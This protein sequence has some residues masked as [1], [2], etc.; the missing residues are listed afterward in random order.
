MYRFVVKKTKTYLFDNVFLDV[1]SVVHA[2][3]SKPDSN[4]SGKCAK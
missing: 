2:M 1:M 4:G 3:L